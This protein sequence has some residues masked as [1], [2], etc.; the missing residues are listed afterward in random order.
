MNLHSQ[1]TITIALSE[2]EALNLAQYLDR[3]S[4]YFKDSI[5][6]VVQDLEVALAN[7]VKEVVRR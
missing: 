6:Q 4:V 1:T 7:E 2:Q 3:A 5:P